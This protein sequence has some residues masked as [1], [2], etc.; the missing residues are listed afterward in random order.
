MT[1][2]EHD[3]ERKDDGRSAKSI[4]VVVWGEN[5]HDRRLPAV[6]AIYPDGMHGCIAAA[7]NQDSGIS[8]VTA[9]LD[10]PDQGLSAELLARTDV[11]TR[12]VA[13]CPP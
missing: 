1:L 9:T 2:K 13:C 12:R 6:R 10:Q 5:V 3:M 7:L 11:L 4:R 8:A